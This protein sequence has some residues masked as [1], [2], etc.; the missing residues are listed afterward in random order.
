LPAEPAGLFGAF[1]AGEP[2]GLFGAFPAGEPAGL[3]GAFPAGEPAGLLGLFG[4]RAAGL[5]GAFRQLCARTFSPA[6][7]KILLMERLKVV[8]NIAIVALIAAAVYF[9]PGGGRASHTFLGVVYIGFAVA[10]GYLGLRLYRE[11]RVALHSLGDVYRGVFYGAIAFAVLAYA[12]RAH[13]GI[14]TR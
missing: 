1:P 14:W 7:P 12:A 10:I 2:A 3:F 4:S 11:H 5:P 9:L 6:A 8:R 13:V